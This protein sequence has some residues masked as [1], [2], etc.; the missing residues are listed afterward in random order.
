MDNKLF[1]GMLIVL[2]SLASCT[3]NVQNSITPPSAA[4]ETAHSEQGLIG[5]TI[6]KY[7]EWDKTKFD[8]AINEGKTVYLEFTANWCGTCQKQ[9]L[10]LKAGF[11]E[12][13]DPNVVG[14]DIHYNDDQT[15]DEHK[16]LSHQYQIAYQHSKVVI[17]NGKVV[18]KS[19]EAWT[20]DKFLE[21]MRKIQSS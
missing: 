6:S 18:L 9:I 20:K 2:V 7:Y 15:T 19:P 11:E 10:H 1:I 21:H 14:F 13:N 3:S 5:G 4:Q 12:L 17:K 16:A 8:K